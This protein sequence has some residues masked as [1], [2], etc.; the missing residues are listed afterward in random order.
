MAH[1]KA[2][3]DE[4]AGPLIGRFRLVFLPSQGQHLGQRQQRLDELARA[5]AELGFAQKSGAAAKD[6]AR[7][8]IALPADERSQ[9]VQGV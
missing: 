1:L 4:R 8:R 7:G 2:R 5:G 6:F 9:Q 3:F